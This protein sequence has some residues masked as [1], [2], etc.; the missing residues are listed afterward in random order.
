MALYH[1]CHQG[2]NPVR[3]ATCLC[4][5]RPLGLQHWPER[6]I[7]GHVVGALLPVIVAGSRDLEQPLQHM[8][9]ERHARFVVSCA[10]WHFGRRERVDSVRHR[11][12]DRGR[13]VRAIGFL[14][15][16]FALLLRARRIA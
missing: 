14:S 6:A 4:T 7:S 8:P 11:K 2:S 15:Q 1:N 13:G 12:R 3:E 10:G 9:A 16:Q 5:G